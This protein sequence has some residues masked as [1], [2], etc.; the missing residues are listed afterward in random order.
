MEIFTKNK[1]DL[2]DRTLQFAKNVVRFINKL[3]RTLA[4]IEYGK[5]VIRSAGSIGAN[6]IEANEALGKRDFRMKIK[7]ARKEAKE[8]AYWLR[9]LISINPKLF[10]KEGKSLISEANELKRIFSSIVEKTK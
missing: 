6:Y 4:N 7:I 10:T 5:Q 9:L 2:E 1:F 3:P 8:T